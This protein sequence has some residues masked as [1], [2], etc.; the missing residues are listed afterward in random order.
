MFASQPEDGNLTNTRSGFERFYDYDRYTDLGTTPNL[1]EK[2]PGF[3]GQLVKL[4]INFLQRKV[5]GARFG[6][7]P[8]LGGTPSL[9]YPRR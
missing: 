2:K 6:P 5:E 9:P 1:D 8:T 7:R 4:V 3:F